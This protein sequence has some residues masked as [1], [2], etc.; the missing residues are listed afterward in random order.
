MVFEG[1]KNVVTMDTKVTWVCVWFL[2]DCQKT[3]LVIISFMFTTLLGLFAQTQN[4]SRKAWKGQSPSSKSKQTCVSARSHCEREVCI[5]TFIGL[6]FYKVVHFRSI[7]LRF[8]TF[9]DALHDLDDC[10]ALCHL[11]ATFT[12]TKSVP[13]KHVRLIFLSWA[14]SEFFLSQSVQLYMF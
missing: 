3:S 13:R 10:L 6:D 14:I 12:H 9:E 2:N 5:H 1:F 4:C 11:Y 7:Q 8:P